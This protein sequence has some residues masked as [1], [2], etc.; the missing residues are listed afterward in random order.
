MKISKFLILFKILKRNIEYFTVSRESLNEIRY[1]YNSD[2][3]CDF[4]N[5]DVYNPVYN[6]TISNFFEFASIGVL[7]NVYEVNCS[8]YDRPNDRWS[9]SGVV[10]GKQVSRNIS[11]CLTD[12]GFENHGAC[13]FPCLT[14][15]HVCL[16]VFAYPCSKSNEGHK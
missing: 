7:I 8:Y 14:V 6:L 11:V 15:S 5:N 16:A 13:V 9:N 2:S 4:E 10:G 12:R 3:D 1:F